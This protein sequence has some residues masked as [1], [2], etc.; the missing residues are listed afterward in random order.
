MGGEK[1]RKRT[2]EKKKKKR[3]RQRLP[4]QGKGEQKEREKER[5]GAWRKGE[6]GNGWG[7]SLKWT[8]YPGDRASQQITASGIK[9]L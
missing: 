8:R 2:T 1:G 9:C 5:G 4:L 7:L 3:E 6:V